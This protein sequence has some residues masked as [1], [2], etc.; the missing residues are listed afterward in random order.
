M[1]EECVNVFAYGDEQFVR[2]VGYRS[3]LAEGN[4]GDIT[5]FLRSK[6]ESDYKH[7]VRI[8]LDPPVAWRDFNSR[9][10]LGWLNEMVEGLTVIPE[11]SFY[12]ITPIVNGVVTIDE[13]VDHLAESTFPDYLKVY[14][15]EGGFDI[16]R[17]INDD[18][19]DAIR[20]LM[21]KQKYVSALKLTLSMIDTLGF[22]EFGPTNDCFIKWLDRYCVMNELGVT[23]NELWELRNSLLHMT[24]LESR[25]VQAGRVKGLMPAMTAPETD[26]PESVV[27]YKNLHVYRFVL[28]VLP[29]G[30]KSWLQSYNTDRDKFVEFVTRYDSVVSEARMVEQH[31]TK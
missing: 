29:E 1:K 2:S 28:K 30:I 23:S 27:G 6:V 31:F 22:I 26:I 3:Y 10:R 11:G 21:N 8:L 20:L 12:C 7:A 4:Y 25:K 15:T 5:H 19:M 13:N 18:Y 16:F 24:N 17:L 14:L 9:C